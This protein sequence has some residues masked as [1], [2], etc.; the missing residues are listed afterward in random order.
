RAPASRVRLHPKLAAPLPQNEFIVGLAGTLGSERGFEPRTGTLAQLL[1][2]SVAPSSPPAAT[3]QPNHVSSTPGEVDASNAEHASR[4]ELRHSMGN[5]D[6]GSSALSVPLVKGRHLQSS[7]PS[8][9]LNGEDEHITIDDDAAQKTYVDITSEPPR[10]QPIDPRGHLRQQAHS[11]RGVTAIGPSKPPYSHLQPIHMAIHIHLLRNI[12]S[13]SIFCPCNT[14][15]P[16]SAFIT[17]YSALITPTSEHLKDPLNAYALLGMPKSYV[18]LVGDVALDARWCWWSG[19]GR[20]WKGKGKE[21]QVEGD[22]DVDMDSAGERQ[23]DDERSGNE[24]ETGNEILSFAL[25]A[26]ND[27]RA[28]EEAGN[29]TVEEKEAGE[30][31]EGD[32]PISPGLE[33]ANVLFRSTTT[34]T[35]FADRQSCSYPNQGCL[36]DASPRPHKKLIRPLSDSLLPFSPPTMSGHHE[37]KPNRNYNHDI[38][39]LTPPLV[40]SPATSLSATLVSSTSSNPKPKSKSRTD[41]SETASAGSVEATATATAVVGEAGFEGDT[42]RIATMIAIWVV[43]RIGLGSGDTGDSEGAAVRNGKR[44]QGKEKEKGP[45]FVRGGGAVANENEDDG[46]SAMTSTREPWNDDDGGAADLGTLSR[47]ACVRDGAEEHDQGYQHQH[48][49]SHSSSR[50]AAHTKLALAPAASSSVTPPVS[51][52]STT[53]LAPTPT[54][55][56]PSPPN[57]ESNPSFSLISAAYINTNHPAFVAGSGNALAASANVGAG[58]PPKGQ[59]PPR[60]TSAGAEP[61]STASTSKAANGSSTSTRTLS[62]DSD[63]S[64]TDSINGIFPPCDSRSVSSTV[65]D[66]SRTR[67][68]T[69]T[70]ST[71]TAV[72]TSKRSSSHHH[73]Q[74]PRPHSSLGTPGVGAPGSSPSST[75]ARETF[76]NYFFGGNAGPGE[77]HGH[78]HH[79]HHSP[80][81]TLNAITP[82]GRDLGNT[83]GITEGRS[84]VFDMKS[85]GKHIEAKWKQP[86][87]SIV[88]QTI[89]DLV[90]KAIMHYLVNHTSSSVQNRLVAELYKPERFGEMLDEDEAVSR[91]RERFQSLLEAYKEAFRTLSESAVSSHRGFLDFD[92]FKQFVRVLNTRPELDQLYRKLVAKAAPP[93]A[94]ASPTVQSSELAEVNETTNPHDM[95][96]SGSIK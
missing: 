56:P 34:Q 7:T 93:S 77:K 92:D 60:P 90:P 74:P 81:P 22:E 82:S 2:T 80:S 51:P 35:R 79:H 85:L 52:R 25:F 13:L 33:D 21:K 23:G 66:R 58:S 15:I 59:I 26:L 24:A 53:E 9:Q 64:D 50:L 43:A 27:L 67:A 4:L 5:D 65:H 87:L 57:I 54:S 28:K 42:L 12:Q 96:M 19:K 47:F 46:A 75:T 73:H 41:F 31:D 8:L 16:S 76:L 72:S 55:S 17:T 37:V 61:S 78:G 62:D 69:G 48:S 1:Y 44:K 38:S 14:S 91:E 30:V 29:G 32:V 40:M 10:P 20:R 83:G 3:L 70:A 36:F 45:G 94:G 39:F 68:S 95:I 71:V 88:R 84:A 63:V 49:F 89:Q 11:W 86:Y 6:E 18:H